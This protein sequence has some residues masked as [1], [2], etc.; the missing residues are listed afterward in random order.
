[1]AEK[2]LTECLTGG[3]PGLLD[4]PETLALAER[5]V[6]EM[7]VGSSDNVRLKA[8]ELVLLKHQIGA[9]ESKK[10][11][12]TRE[13]IEHLRGIISE[14]KAVLSEHVGFYERKY[15]SGSPAHGIEGTS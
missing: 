9:P 10:A 13:D 14:V 12:I 8:A 7:L 3:E 6:A 2:T 1:M 5:S 4:L 15:G 11:S